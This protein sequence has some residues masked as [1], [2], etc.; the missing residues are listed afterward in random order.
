MMMISALPP[1]PPVAVNATSGPDVTVTT[2][3]TS[4]PPSG[5]YWFWST[6]T[7]K[8]EP[9]SVMRTLLGYGA[10][11]TSGNG[12]STTVMLSMPPASRANF[13]NESAALDGSW[14]ASGS[15]I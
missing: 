11:R 9:D 12:I 2:A 1:G 6:S 8:A 15:A 5:T 14:N 4:R 3:L 7:V 13:S 10:G